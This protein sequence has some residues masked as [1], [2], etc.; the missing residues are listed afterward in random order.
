MPEMADILRAAVPEYLAKYGERMLPSHKRALNDIVLCRTRPLGGKT[1]YCEPCDQ[2]HY[3]YY[4]CK[5]RSCPKC[6]NEDAT[7]WLTA[8]SA[9]LLPVQYFMVTTTLPAQLRPVARRNQKLI[10]GLLLR[11]S[12]GA[13]QRLASD[14][15]WVGGEIGLLG[16]P[17]T[18][19]RD[20][21][22]QC[23]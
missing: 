13:I 7:R 11:C 12:A 4:S 8:Q 20:M 3:S 9:L 16:V 18:W 17:Q 5:N 21:R 23:A 14:P 15:E 10:Y 2:Y 1:Y 6:G 22:Y 19:R